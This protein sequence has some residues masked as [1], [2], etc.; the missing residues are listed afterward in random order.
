MKYF[1]IPKVLKAILERDKCHRLSLYLQHK[2]NIEK[3]WFTLG[4]LYM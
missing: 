3:G 4:G 2:T 1:Q